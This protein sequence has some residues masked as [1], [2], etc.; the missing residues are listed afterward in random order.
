MLPCLAENIT[1]MSTYFFI[2]I[3]NC[4]NW[5][6]SSQ[7]GRAGGQNDYG[8]YSGRVRPYFS[9]LRLNRL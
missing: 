7:E 4:F 1:S 5:F 3:N 9:S 2:K 6:F 8:A